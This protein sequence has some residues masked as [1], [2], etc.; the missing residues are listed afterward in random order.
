M[1]GVA[2]RAG[3]LLVA[4]FLGYGAV[5]LLAVAAMVSSASVRRLEHTAGGTV[6][7]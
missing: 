7:A 5:V 3:V 6:A 1:L 4:G 2:P